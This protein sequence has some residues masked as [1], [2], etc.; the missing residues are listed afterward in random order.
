MDKGKLKGIL[1]IALGVFVLVWTYQHRPSAALV[2]GING[3]F[4][5]ASYSMSD[6]WYYI[7]LMAGAVITALG[8]RNLIK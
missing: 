1:L 4:D 6:T 8:L 2:N 3:L 5:D 7:C